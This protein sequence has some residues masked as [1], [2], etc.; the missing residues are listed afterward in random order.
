MRNDFMKID[1]NRRY[2]EKKKK[3]GLCRSCNNRIYRGGLCKKHWN[4]KKKR[5][6]EYFRKKRKLYKK[7]I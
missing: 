5:H 3:L 6:K 1:I 2:I 7:Q 4:K